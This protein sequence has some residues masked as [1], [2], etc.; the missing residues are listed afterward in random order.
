VPEPV[1]GVIFPH[2]PQQPW[3]RGLESD[4]EES[5]RRFRVTWTDMRAKLT[6]ADIEAAG[7][8]LRTTN[9]ARGIAD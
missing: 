9:A 2:L 7:I 5:K 8:R 1:V 3:H 6:E 4:L